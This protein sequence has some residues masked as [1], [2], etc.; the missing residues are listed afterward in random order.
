MGIV[1]PTFDGFRSTAMKEFHFFETRNLLFI[2][3]NKNDP[4]LKNINQRRER[5]CI[6]ITLEPTRRRKQF[7]VIFND[8]M[9]F[10][11]EIVT[12]I[13]LGY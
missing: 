6:F 8:A 5:K 1:Y 10:S 7:L 4:F 12:F 11:R 9:L 13:C 2:M 3:N